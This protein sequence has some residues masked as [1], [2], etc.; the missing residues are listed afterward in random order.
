[1]M[2]TLITLNFDGIGVV[3]ILVVIGVATIGIV[4]KLKGGK[5]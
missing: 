2:F 5:R 1:M 4:T 3:L